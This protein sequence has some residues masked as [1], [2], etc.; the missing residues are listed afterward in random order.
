M[1]S[2]IGGDATAA[3]H[4]PKDWVPT[5]G[6]SI[7]RAE[8]NIAKQGRPESPQSYMYTQCVYTCIYILFIFIFACICILKLSG[9]QVPTD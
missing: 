2:K 1:S 3:L 4:K 8:L 9:F 5:S 6:H 7:A